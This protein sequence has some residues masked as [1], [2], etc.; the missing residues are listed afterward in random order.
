MRQLDRQRQNLHDF[1]AAAVTPT[2]IVMVFLGSGHCC[3]SVC[4]CN[5][6]VSDCS[7][8]SLTTLTPLLPLLDQGC[9]TLRL[10]QNNLSTLAP[11]DFGNLTSLEALDL[12]QNQLSSLSSGA[13]SNLG[14]LHWLNLSTNLL[15]ANL[16]T[17]DFNASEEAD[18]GLKKGVFKGLW[19][20]RGLDL[21]S[22]DLPWLPTG[23]L[24]GLQRLS[25]L[26]LARNRLA[27]LERATFEPL[28]GLQH[29]HLI[30]NPWQCDCKM[31][32]FKHWMEWMIYR[33]GLVDAMIC[34][35]PR[36][37]L[38][39]DI[40]R[41][42]AEMFTH[43]VQ[44]ANRESASENLSR[45]P[46]P[47]GRLSITDDCVRQ[48]YRPISV[49]RA[50]GTQIVAGVVCGTVCIMMVVAATYGCI[51]ASL[52]AR[53]Q[54]GVK[55]RGEPLMAQEGPDGDPEEGLEETTP[56]EACV[57]YGYRISSF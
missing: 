50:H 27:I 36:K 17:E 38:G 22:N 51:Y 14:S 6:S 29:L 10:F 15:G 16:T 7:G 24:D 21:S 44:S 49:R 35:L 43:C 31:T 56:K 23:L 40:R 52:M 26:S 1:L 46:C 41:V 34:S 53:Y 3:P 2:L 47:P 54:R 8:L 13:F 28:M 25:W 42:P 5:G 57:V 39:R 45:P 30:G 11:V 12:S 18:R 48:R 9:V 20:L 55:N 32:G 33:D 4:T 37:L 19:W